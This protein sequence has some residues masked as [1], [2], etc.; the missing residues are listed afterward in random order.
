MSTIEKSV[1]TIKKSSISK[2]V[3]ILKEVSK[4]G[5]LDESIVLEDAIE[6]LESFSEKNELSAITAIAVICSEMSTQ[7]II[8][9]T[10]TLSSLARVKMVKD[11]LKEDATNRNI[12]N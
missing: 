4:N 8:S 9:L 7:A 5:K 2:V 10:K 6:I 1:E 11:I 3:N 12:N